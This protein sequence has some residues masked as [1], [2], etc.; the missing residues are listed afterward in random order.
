MSNSKTETVSGWTFL[1]VEG[2]PWNREPKSSCVNASWFGKGN[3]EDATIYTNLKGSQSFTSLMADLL[4]KTLTLMEH[5]F[6]GN[7]PLRQL[8]NAKAL[9]MS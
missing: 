5:F 9:F 2:G 7:I 6:H 3:P 8:L 4:S 1:N